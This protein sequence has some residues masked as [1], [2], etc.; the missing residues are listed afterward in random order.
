MILLE[1]NFKGS[2]LRIKHAEEAGVTTYSFS[3]E[4]EELLGL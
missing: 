2:P 1:D 3:S 4:N